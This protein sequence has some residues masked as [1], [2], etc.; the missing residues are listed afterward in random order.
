MSAH[1]P[2]AI[3]PAKEKNTLQFGYQHRLRQ[4]C[5]ELEIRVP[6]F[7]EFDCECVD[8]LL[9][10]RLGIAAEDIQQLSPSDA[11]SHLQGDT[12]AKKKSI[13]ARVL[14]IARSLLQAGNIP[15]FDTGII[16]ALHANLT[17]ADHFRARIAVPRVDFLPIHLNVS[18]INAAISI[19][20]VLSRHA[21]DTPVDF[22]ALYRH[23]ESQFLQTIL[24]AVFGSISTLPILRIVYSANIPARHLGG[25]VY[26][27]GWG[28]RARLIDRSASD[29]DSAIGARLGQSK[30][31]SAQML[32]VAGLPAPVHQLITSEADLLVAAQQ[33][34][35]PV[36]VKPNDRDRGE[37][38]TVNIK[39]SRTLLQAYRYAAKVSNQVLIEKQVP[40]MCYRLLIANGK[41]LYAIRRRPKSL[42]GDGQLTVQQLA[43]LA[44]EQEARKPS[45][46]RAPLVPLDAQALACIAHQGFTLDAI[47][48]VDEL[49]ALRWIESSE[50][51]G[52]MEDVTDL[53]HPDNIDAAVR[54]ASL[55]GLSNAGV[56]MIAVDIGSAWH[57]TPAIINEI[58]FTPYLGGNPIARSRIPD[59]VSALIQGDGRVPVFVF[60]GDGS[61]MQA[62]VSLHQQHLKLGWA[63]YLS[64]HD[65]TLD[66]QAR[67]FPIA[68]DGL[69]QR[70]L[71]L[72]MNRNVGALI[73]VAQT[74]E[75][76]QTGLPVDRFQEVHLCSGSVQA[77]G[78]PASAL[79]DDVRKH[80]LVT[81]LRL[82]D[83]SRPL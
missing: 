20:G 72:L 41:L 81:L 15:V 40:G 73:L 29:A 35:W 24:R 39:D 28:K 27:L 76:L 56:D 8:Q 45:W 62:A 1:A 38:V 3:D 16:L 70:S 37:G 53:A 5:S 51:G 61:A 18:A 83:I 44:L 46:Q 19:L 68:Q 32:R 33:F 13:C 11:R 55:F 30:I 26:Q 57:G 71:A 9:V 74:D 25:G 78:K 63:S 75:L 10:Q 67:I 21:I 49:V 47:P 12:D 42:K 4:S 65:V 43:E 36:V 17:P 77:W 52:Y 66:E 79:N 82:Y 59:Y 64:S 50:W 6:N 2:K 22:A 14:V 69:F 80:E 34:G 31:W 60:V 54:A 58:N 7:E 48:Q 23:I